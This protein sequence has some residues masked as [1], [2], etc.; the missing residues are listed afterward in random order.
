MNKLLDFM[1]HL[2]GM[3]TQHMLVD[4]VKSCSFMDYGQ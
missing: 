4:F 1:F 3:F 2:V